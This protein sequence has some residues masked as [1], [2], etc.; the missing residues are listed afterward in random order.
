MRTQRQ[1]R[2]AFTLVEL[3]VAMALTIFVMTIL[4]QAF[5]ISIDTFV[6]LKAIG[7][8]QDNLRSAA[9]TIRYDLVQDHF[10]GKRRVSDNSMIATPPVQGFFKVMPGSGQFIEGVD[11]D[12]VNSTRAK[13]NDYVLW[14]FSRLKG[15]QQ[16]SFYTT[17]VGDPTF[18]NAQTFYNMNP[19]VLPGVDADATLRYPPASPTGPFLYRSQCAEIVY[20]LGN[21]Q[22]GAILPVGTTETPVDPSGTG[23]PLFNLYRAQ[24][25]AVTDSTQLNAA[26]YP[27]ANLGNF[28]GIACVV[29][30]NNPPTLTFLTAEDM[31][32]GTRTWT[33]NNPF[34]NASLVVPNVLSFQVQC[35]TAA[36]NV[37]AASGPVD[38]NYDS[39]TTRTAFLGVWINLRVWD[40]KT[41]QTRQ[42]TILQDL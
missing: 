39:A 5:V 13:N 24:Y 37:V 22:T 11:G 35:V 2:S 10:E 42:M 26:G 12:N 25:V 38:L 27:A 4:T 41:R 20:F 14:F 9:S 19:V 7:D 28:P 8:M 16:Q 31:A 34:R 3:M 36:A 30:G 17:Q 32:S 6:G 18:F 33:A 40:N 23:M 21:P 1:S 29:N 15:N